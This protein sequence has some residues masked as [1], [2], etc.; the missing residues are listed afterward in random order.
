MFLFLPFTAIYVCLYGDT[1]FFVHICRS[2]FP[3]HV[4]P[5]ILQHETRGVLIYIISCHV[6]SYCLFLFFLYGFLFSL[7]LAFDPG[8]HGIQI[9]TEFLFGLGTHK[10]M[11]LGGGCFKIGFVADTARCI[12]HREIEETHLHLTS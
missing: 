4:L 8:T 9:G 3:V 10:V 5:Y 2:I 7:G 11:A 6:M 12:V 1:N